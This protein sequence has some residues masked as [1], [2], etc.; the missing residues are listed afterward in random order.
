MSRYLG[1]AI[2]TAA[3]AAAPRYL[4]PGRC[5]AARPGAQSRRRGEG[6]GR[7]C[8]A[9]RGRADRGHL[10]PLFLLGSPRH[11]TEGVRG[12]GDLPSHH[13]E[14]PFI[15]PR[16]RSPAGQLGVWQ[17]RERCV[18]PGSRLRTR[19]NQLDGELTHQ[20][21]ERRNRAWEPRGTRR[22][23]A[24]AAEAPPPAER[25]TSRFQV[26]FPTPRGENW[27]LSVSTA[28]WGQGRGTNP[29]SPSEWLRHP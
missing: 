8:A 23:A 14:F 28:S 24:P 17:A 26:L 29:I 13:Q 16:P 25:A 9:A 20:P 1:T 2:R 19:A 18:R 22:R 6:R 21:A 12:G 15:H 10:S 5:S 11:F 3:R 7:G 27:G 4:T